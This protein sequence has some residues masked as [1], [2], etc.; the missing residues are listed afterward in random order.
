MH[1]QNAIEDIN[2][3]GD[4]D[5]LVLNL[6]ADESSV[7]DRIDEVNN[8]L[9]DNKITLTKAKLVLIIQYKCIETWL[10]GNRRIIKQN[11]ISQELRDYKL[12]YDVKNE[13]PENMGKIDGFNTHSQFHFAY[14]KEIFRERNLSYSKANPSEAMK[15]S[16]L[17]Q[18][19]NR[20]EKFPSH[21]Q[22]FQV[23]LEFC[24]EIKSQV[25]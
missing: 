24:E 16:Y 6:D 13:D 19:L 8:F 15:K 10:L 1:L 12:F 5:Y 23:F 14:L 3:S 25:N 20:V 9:N 21:L 18:L 4:F 22:T 7:Q 11:P 2:Q 17:N